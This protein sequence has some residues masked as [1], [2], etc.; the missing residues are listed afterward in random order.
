[1]TTLEKSKEWYEQEL[2]LRFR[3]FYGQT[4]GTDSHL[5]VG[6]LNSRGV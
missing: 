1:M 2:K 4:D 6:N 3:H 5:I